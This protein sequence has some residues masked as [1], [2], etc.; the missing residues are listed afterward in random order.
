MKLYTAPELV[1]DDTGEPA[2][3]FLAGSIEQNQASDWQKR[4]LTELAAYPVAVFNPRRE[5][6][7]AS[8]E[9]SRV[10]GSGGLGA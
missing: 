2:N 1:P 5:Q 7:D 3:L 6:W 10:Q 9:Q 4:V 8:W